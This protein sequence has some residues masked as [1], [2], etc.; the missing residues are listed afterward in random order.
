MFLEVAVVYHFNPQ[1]KLGQ[2]DLSHPFKSEDKILW[3]YGTHSFP[4]LDSLATI[5]VVLLILFPRI[6][7]K[8]IWNFKELFTLAIT[9]KE[10]FRPSSLTWQLTLAIGWQTNKFNLHK[11]LQEPWSFHRLGNFLRFWATYSFCYQ[12]VFSK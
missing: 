5:W 11:T 8:D 6:L 1:A 12:T 3:C 4:T 9:K 10:S 7:Q 2:D